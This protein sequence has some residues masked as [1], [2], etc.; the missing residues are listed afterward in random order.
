MLKTYSSGIMNRSKRAIYRLDSV[1]RPFYVYCLFYAKNP[2]N[3]TYNKNHVFYVGKAKNTTILAYRRE[4]EHIR[5]AYKEESW[6]F[7][8]S[9]KIRLLEKQGYYIMSKVLEEF[10]LENEAYNAERK[11]EKF[12]CNNGNNLTNMLECGIKYL[13]SGVD[14]PSFDPKL[15]EHSEEIIKLYT[16]SFWSIQ[17]ICK[18]FNV[19]QKTIKKIL[20]QESNNKQRSKNLRSNIWEQQKEIVRLYKDN[21]AT[22]KLAKKYKCSTNTIINILRA[23]NILIR[24]RAPLKKSSKAW[25]K[26]DQII[27]EF[28]SGKSRQYLC[29]KYRCDKKSTLI[30]IL[31]EAGLI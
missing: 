25:L 1:S 29:Q 14:H 2:C 5:E 6:N 18:Y 23:N 17:K 10:Q 15:R 12:F 26:K 8:K 3:I 16:I 28:T 11:W 30:P 4:R 7:H 9:R 22:N 13:G 31:T 20:F 21:I 24:S 27:K 19:S